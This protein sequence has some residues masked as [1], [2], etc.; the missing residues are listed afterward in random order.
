MNERVRSRTP[1][2]VATSAKQAIAV[3]VAYGL[4][5]VCTQLLWLTY[6][7]ITARASIDFGVP[8]SAVGDLAVVVPIMFV[9]LGL[10][11]GR[12]LDRYFTTTMA[13]GTLLILLGAAVRALD[14]DDYTFAIIGQLLLAAGQPLVLNAITKLPAQYFPSEQRV[15]AI[16]L[17]TAAQVFGILLASSTG[18]WLHSFGGL[19]SLVRT[20]AVL[21]VLCGVLMLAAL[22]VKPRFAEHET[23]SG[24]VRLRR[25]RQLWLL[26]GQAFVGL[27]LFN[28]LATWLDSIETDL[29]NPGLG[30][31]MVTVMTAAGIGG[32]AVLPS[33]A[34]R[35]GRRRR[36][37]V[38]IGLGCTF[39]TPLL[40][41]VRDPVGSM[42]IIAVIGMLLISGLPIALDWSEAM[43][44]REHAGAAAAFILVVANLGGSLYTVTLQFFVDDPAVAI[45]VLA[46]LVLP[47]PALARAQRVDAPI[48]I[49]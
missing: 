48:G 46:V 7:P 49:P 24:P 38:F 35:F 5:L 36:T 39:G 20:H 23:T 30:G 37:L 33:V 16:S 10:P 12:W 15:R 9:L 47:W 42:V 43:V 26:A 28:A 1:R 21:A 29:G 45:A 27:G 3:A 17:L 6:A 8:E 2:G 4:L 41:V 40:L 32:A 13:A 34:A 18:A 31:P 14:S 19:N 11:S 25:H 22:T 44:G